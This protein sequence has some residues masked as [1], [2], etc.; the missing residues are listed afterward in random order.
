VPTVRI[1]SG[2]LLWDQAQK[3]CQDEDH[4]PSALLALEPGLYQHTCR[5]CG[6]IQVFEIRPEPLLS[7]KK[8]RPPA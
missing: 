4:H 3:T 1:G 2:K 5:K 8:L 6:K 7:G